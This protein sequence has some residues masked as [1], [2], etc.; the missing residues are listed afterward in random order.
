MAQI[1]FD[2]FIIQNSAAN[3][4]ENKFCDIF[5]EFRKNICKRLNII[6]HIKTICQQ[7]FFVFM[8]GNFQE[9]LSS[10]DIF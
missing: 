8:L 10:V 1:L 2:N 5:I 9:F 4:A 7:V 6:S 3:A